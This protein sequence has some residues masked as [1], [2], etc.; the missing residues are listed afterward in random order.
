MGLNSLLKKTTIVSI[1]L[2]SAAIA[3]A[4]TLRYIPVTNLTDVAVASYDAAGPVVY[5]NPTIAA[6]LDPDVFLFF[7][8]H[9]EA[10]HALNHLQ[11][12]VFDTNPYNRA[13]VQQSYEREADCYAAKELASTNPASI[14]ETVSFFENIIP[15][16]V[17]WYHPPGY[18]RAAVI[19][20]CAKGDTSTK[21]TKAASS[22]DFCSV[23]QQYVDAKSNNFSNLK[24]DYKSEGDYYSTLAVPDA[25]TCTVSMS[26][27]E[28]L[29]RRYFMH[30]SM[31]L[32]YD[33]LRENVDSCYPTWQVEEKFLSE[34]KKDV[35]E[36]KWTS[37]DGAVIKIREIDYTTTSIAT[38]VSLDVK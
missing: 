19:R 18:E 4:Q 35:K 11:R 15:G 14:T 24:G 38:Q 22:S 31:N 17:D 28:S 5:Y 34:E 30:C 27:V 36:K 3:Y 13:W 32:D 23:L 7:K 8:K 20:S 33:S 2:L 21:A 12:S 25:R 9:E 16:Q 1:T 10:H 37:S 26:I 29:P 6:Q